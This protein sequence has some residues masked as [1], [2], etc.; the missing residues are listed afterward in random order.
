MILGYKIVILLLSRECETWCLILKG[1]TQVEG[2]RKNG[3]DQDIC[4]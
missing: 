2:E 4:T 3:V 1:K